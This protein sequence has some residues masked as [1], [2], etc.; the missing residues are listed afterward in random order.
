ML[1][2]FDLWRDLAIMFESPSKLILITVLVGL[3]CLAGTYLGLTIGKYHKD[4]ASAEADTTIASLRG[5][6]GSLQQKIIQL[7]ARVRDSNSQRQQQVA[8]NQRLQGTIL[9]LRSE[10]RE[11]GTEIERRRQ[12]HPKVIL[13]E[14]DPEPSSTNA[15]KLSLD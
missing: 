4:A 2:T 3:G 14:A 6:V 12:E 8:E 11:R 1:D 9:Q 15:E 10:M 13:K 5:D 7:N